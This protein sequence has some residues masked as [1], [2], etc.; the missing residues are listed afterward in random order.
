MKT[1]IFKGRL[2]CISLGKSHAQNHAM[3]FLSMRVLLMRC[4]VQADAEA[5]GKPCSHCWAAAATP[6]INL[7]CPAQCA[8][9]VLH[10]QVK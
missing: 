9:T 10:Q 1:A 4:M 8:P 3:A 2:H 6:Q 5:S 7:G